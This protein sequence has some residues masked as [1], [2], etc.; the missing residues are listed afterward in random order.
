MSTEIL[1]KYI[2][3]IN[4]QE[5]LNEEMLEEGMLQRLAGFALGTVLALGPKIGQADTVYSYLPATGTQMQTAMDFNQIPKDAKAVFE[6]DTDTNTVHVLSKVNF[7]GKKPSQG[8]EVKPDPTAV[9]QGQQGQAQV[10]AQP[11]AQQPQAQQPQPSVSNPETSQQTTQSN[12][13]IKGIK[14]GMTQKEVKEIAKTSNIK[15]PAI[16]FAGKNDM[17]VNFGTVLGVSGAD[18]SV[19]QLMNMSDDEKFRVMSNSG[20]PANLS[21]ENGKLVAITIGNDS[22]VIATLAQQLIAKFGKPTSIEDKEWQNKAGAKFDNQVMFWQNAN[23][24][25]IKLGIRGN[26]RDDGYVVIADPA[27]LDKMTKAQVEKNTSNLADFE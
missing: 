20:M 27:H 14:F 12:F 13:S 18:P 26:T 9:K 7:F 22:G 16:N 6:I 10:A 15:T 21:F 24:A 3:I 23:G 11:Q 17:R 4:E 25:A 1:R 8:Q 19:A 2:D 5:T